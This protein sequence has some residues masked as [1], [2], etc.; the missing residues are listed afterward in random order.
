MAVDVL[1]ACSAIARSYCAG[2]V[3]PTVAQRELCEIEVAVLGSPALLV[4][5]ASVVV[6]QH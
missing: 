6:K 3:L 5:T 2:T 4:R 1:P